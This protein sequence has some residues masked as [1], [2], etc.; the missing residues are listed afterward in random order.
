V[1]DAARE[2]AVLRAVLRSPLTL[3]QR[4]A[5]IDQLRREGVLR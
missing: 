4:A 3:E 5:L 2:V 1:T